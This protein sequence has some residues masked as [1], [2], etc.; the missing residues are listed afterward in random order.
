[1]QADVLD[2]G[3]DNG[4]AT[5]LSGEHVD[6]IGAL[7]HIDFPDSQWH[8]SSECVDASSEETHKTSTGALRPQLGCV[9]PLDSAERT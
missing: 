4:Q 2:R 8:W 7:P 3:P 1:M 5:G 6:L 9:P